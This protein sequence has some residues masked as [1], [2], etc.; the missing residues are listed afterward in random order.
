[1]A[2]RWI[3]GAGAAIAGV[4][5]VGALGCDAASALAAARA[6]LSRASVL[7]HFRKRSETTGVE[8]P[9]IGHG[10]AVL[11]QG[12]EGAVRLR[13]LARGAMQ[14]LLGGALDPA[15]LQQR[16]GL[17]V[18]L[19]DPAR[20]RSCRALMAPPEAPAADD[21]DA[22]PGA[23]VRALVHAMV[24]DV[25]WPQAP[26]ALFWNHS[27]HAA[28]AVAIAA[29]ARD[30]QA[31][32]IDTG[33]VL[34]VDSLLDDDTLTWLD[35][36]GRLKCDAAPA[37]LCPGEAAVALALRRGAESAADAP[38][39]QALAMGEEPLALANGQLC[40]GQALA[41]TLSMALGEEPLPSAWLFS[42]HNGE[43]YRAHELGSAVARLRA[44]HEGFAAPELMFPALAFGDTGAASAPLA[45]AMARHAWQRGCAPGR[46]ALLAACSDDGARVA[47]RLTMGQSR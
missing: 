8:E 17:Y 13:Q 28:G 26:A 40:T 30:L 39:L 1:V 42:D 25:A 6:G 38:R 36:T 24:A 27:G 11:T 14:D 34:A 43:H 29:A 37:G 41:E 44:L 10:A 35:L 20:P 3:D 7:P 18:A 46:T 33:I 4:G 22:E 47:L 15:V 31:G 19:P 45:A 5:L 21:E 12:L 23:A 32:E 16:V 2:S 9:V